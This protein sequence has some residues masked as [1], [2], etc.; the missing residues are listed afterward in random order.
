[1]TMNDQRSS[2][3]SA[4]VG[5]VL[6]RNKDLLR[7]AG[8]LAATTGLTSLFGFVFWIV[9]DR[10]FPKAEVGHAIA[11]TNAMQLLGTIGMFGLGTMMI[12]ELPRRL[13]DRGGLF[14]ASLATSAI[15]SAVLGVIFAVFIGLYFSDRNHLPGIAGTPGQALIFI[16]GV[17]LTGATMVFDEGT[18]GLLRGGV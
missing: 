4:R 3:L 1:M 9:A 12:G 10:E 17:I 7:N 14:A 2:G 16:V 15:G 5:A 6:A 11:A 13:R 18:I 8:S